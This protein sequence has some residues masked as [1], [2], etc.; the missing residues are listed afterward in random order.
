MSV[1]IVPLSHFLICMHGSDNK[2]GC[3]PR[4]IQILFLFPALGL[5]SDKKAGGGGG[6][7]LLR[8]HIR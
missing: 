3:H 4:A 1:K 7:P 2:E 6:V 5:L 8:H